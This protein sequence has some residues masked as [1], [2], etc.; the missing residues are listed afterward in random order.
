MKLPHLLL[1]TLAAASP[2]ISPTR[3][4][5]YEVWMGTLGWQRGMLEHPEQWSRTAALAEGLNVNWAHGQPDDKRL[6]RESRD[7]VVAMFAKANDHA[8][9][10]L[11]HGK[12]RI[13]A[14]TEWARAFDRSEGGGYH[15]DFLYSYNGGKGKTWKDGEHELLRQWL[16]RTGHEDVKIAFNGRSGHGQLER[17]V[18]R[19]NGIECDLR[20]WK[21][22]KGG[23]HELLRWMA[24]PDNAATKG[25]KIIIHCHLNFGKGSDEADL[26]GAWAGARR[27]VRDI[28]RD[29]M[30]TEAL[31][32]VFA[33]DRLVFSFFGGNWTTPEISL[34]PETLGNGDYAESYT[35]MLLSLIEQRDLFEGRSGEFPSDAQCASF[36]RT[37]ADPI[38]STPQGIR[39]GG[40]RQGLGSRMESSPLPARGG[41]GVDGHEAGPGAIGD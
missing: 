41:T 18:V 30:N 4:D 20:S 27:M 15:L 40:G 25:E 36:A 17:P 32:Q 8:Y 6:G 29:V 31:R 12:G 28:G 13:T 7:D 33:S 26:K 10:V 19:G 14:D 16:D 24:D 3:G 2:A 11:P 23:R 5:A 22:N 1:I 34:L 9:Q 38:G 37:A 35:G 39:D 21:E